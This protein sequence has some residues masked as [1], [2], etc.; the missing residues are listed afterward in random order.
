M[1]MEHDVF[2][3]EGFYEPTV[4]FFNNDSY[5]SQDEY[6]VDGMESLIPNFNYKRDNAILE[7]CENFGR[8]LI[9][10]TKWFQRLKRYMFSFTTRKVGVTD[11]GDFFGSP[12]LG[13][14][15]ITFT[16]ADRNEWFTDIWDVDEEE[17]KENLHECKWVNK[18]WA[19]T[20]DVFNLTIPYLLWKIQFSKQLPSGLKREAQIMVLFMYHC[21]CI[22]SMIHNDYPYLAKP[23]IV[24][25]TYNRLSLKYDI[26]KYESWRA[27]FI[28]RAEFILS[29][30]TGIHYR[31]FMNMNDDK[32][33]IYMV[34]DIQDRL[35]GLVNDINKVFHDVKNR[36]NIMQ[37]DKAQVNMEE[38][39]TVKEITKQVNVYKNYAKTILTA[40]TGFYRE[41]FADIITKKIDSAPKDKLERILKEFPGNY[42][43]KSKRGEFYR[44]F[45]DEVLT[46]LFEYLNSN[47]IRQ[48]NLREVIS[49]M[50]GTYASPRNQ[51]VSVLKIRSMG[52]DIV[53]D[54]TGIRTRST[55]SAL[56]T[57]L[58]LY[59]V[60][61]VLAKDNV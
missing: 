46:H 4:S 36:T 45:V 5:V 14:Q 55:Y 15:K 3:G 8:D 13:L 25:E 39:M 1:L 26:K 18:D 42:Q 12:Y 40:P 19:V 21:K 44:E 11:Y 9:I 28:A 16:T 59:I 51:N 53:Q 54:L 23:E 56:R 27:L 41:S 47:R 52:D 49:R 30:T 61:R 57:A 60:L 58:M 20:G 32:K 31:T 29:P 6:L 7:V 2:G 33:I 43:S 10:D 24:Y 34:G 35:R 22:T 37:L 48:T 17:L 50:A 38:G